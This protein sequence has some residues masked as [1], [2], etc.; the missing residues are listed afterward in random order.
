MKLQAVFWDYPKFTDKKYLENILNSSKE[1]DIRLWIM[2]RFLE[3][4]RVVDTLHFFSIDEISRHL[5][6]LKLTDY[7]RKKWTRLIEVYQDSQRK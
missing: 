3:H 7:S 6:K 4:G 1:T 2:T 5:P